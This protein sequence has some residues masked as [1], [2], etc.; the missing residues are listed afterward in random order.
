[1]LEVDV[2]SESSTPSTDV[3]AVHLYAPAWSY[4]AVVMFSVL[5]DR[6]S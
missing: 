2:C 1:M 4:R 6:G 3:V 5:T